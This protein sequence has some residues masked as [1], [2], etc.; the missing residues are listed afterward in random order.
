VVDCYAVLS[1]RDLETEV[2]EMKRQLN[3]LLHPP[4]PPKGK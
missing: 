4:E 2:K 1:K 3:D